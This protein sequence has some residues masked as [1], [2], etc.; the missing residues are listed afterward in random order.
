MHGLTVLG[1][2]IIIF[3]II[4]TRRVSGLTSSA[5]MCANCTKQ[6]GTYYT[7]LEGCN[8]AAC[9]TCP[10]VANGTN[11][12][13]PCTD[14]TAANPTGSAGSCTLTC[15]RGYSI[16]TDRRSCV[17]D[18]VGGWGACSTQCGPGEFTYQVSTQAGPGGQACR[19]TDGT[20]RNQGDK[21][22]CANPD[23]PQNCEGSWS[24][25]GSCSSICGYGTKTRKFTGTKQA[26]NGGT[27]CET[28]YGINAH[29]P[30]SYE[31]T[32]CT[33]LP[34]C[35]SGE[36]CQ[37][38]WSGW[39]A[40]S[41]TCDGGIQTKTY[42]VKKAA[43]VGT[44]GTRG[45]A[46]PHADGATQQQSCN[47]QTCC[48]SA[49]T[50]AWQKYGSV[51]CSG[52]S[53][54]KPEQNYA[55]NINFPAGT[56]VNKTAASCSIQQFYTKY[57]G[58]GCPD[59]T[60]T[61]GTCAVTGVNWNAT[62]GCKLTPDTK[63]PTDG[64]CSPS[65]GSW[66]ATKGC[67]IDPATQQP[68]SGACSDSGVTWSSTSGCQKPSRVAEICI[69]NSCFM[70]RP[71]GGACPSGYSATYGNSR[72]CEVN[73]ESVT[74]PTGYILLYSESRYS[75]VLRKSGYYC[76]FSGTHPSITS[77]QCPGGYTAD[78]PNNTCKASPV[79]IST[80]NCPANYTADKT[81]NTCK[82]NNP[83]SITG[84]TCPGP[85]F[86]ENRTTNKCS[87]T[88]VGEEEPK[89]TATGD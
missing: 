29:W 70:S 10:T 48:S 65:Q 34:A 36:A 43:T 38:E 22:P 75:S 82:A 25:Y 12:L 69:N 54:G 55:R 27:A 44:D 60:P 56:P 9:S 61:E 83:V 57:T 1:L 85:Y 40:C 72:L 37:G 73:P 47:Q 33:G 2:V 68:T 15:D 3:L 66:S 21:K 26:R 53:S 28:T 86:S 81:N 32:T 74:C 52:N 39:G 87:A 11:V 6:P 78:I 17:P 88:T 42:N 64:T 59:V 63:P 13:T 16:S 49:T 89:N 24:D 77:L 67:T 19:D 4:I 46:C 23:C 7:T 5:S 8:T 76:E 14:A 79:T 30:D 41:A 50:G 35:T 51:R 71:S 20:V 62:D 45:A 58:T 80:L 31:T 18:C 84:L